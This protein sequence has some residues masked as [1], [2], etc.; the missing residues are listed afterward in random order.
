MGN[1]GPDRNE[2]DAT[3]FYSDAQR[4]KLITG[5]LSGAG[6]VEFYRQHARRLGASVLE[7]AC[8]TGRLSVPI[9]KDGLEVAG[10]DASHE[11]LALAR[12]KASASGVTVQWIQGDMRDFDL[13]RSFDGIFLAS[14]S[15]SHLYSLTE[16]EACLAAVRRHLNPSGRF[17]V[18]VFNPEL[19]MLLRRP[20]LRIA[21]TAYEE[22]HT[23]RRISVSKSLRYDSATQI[24]HETWYFHDDL[25][26]EEQAIPLNLRMFFPQ[27]IEAL[28]HYNGFSIEAKDGDH[29]D[30]PFGDSSYKQ[31]VMCRVAGTS[32]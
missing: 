29:E 7:L 20:D 3:A 16:S 32:G 28:V 14:N 9:A 25:T 26:G 13:G 15:F 12:R 8:G 11:M 30:T 4:Y 17:V 1:A 24:S 21:V 22:L 27:E 19:G 6:P 5:A 23:G 2:T 18:D 10:L 31:I